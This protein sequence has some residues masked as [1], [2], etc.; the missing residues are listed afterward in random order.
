M[1]SIAY[2]CIPEFWQHSYFIVMLLIYCSGE[3]PSTNEWPGSLEIKK[4]VSLGV[5]EKLL[6]LLR[7]SRKRTIMVTIISMLFLLLIYSICTS[8]HILLANSC[9]YHTYMIIIDCK[10]PVETCALECASLWLHLTS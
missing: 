4:R 6:G 9:F 3:K 7:E 8:L 5:F 10:H 1:E 2:V